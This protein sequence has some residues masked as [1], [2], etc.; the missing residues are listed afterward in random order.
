MSIEYET[1]TASTSSTSTDATASLSASLKDGFGAA[2]P[3]TSPPASTLKTSTA[4]IETH[5]RIAVL[6]SSEA[7]ADMQPGR[8]KAGTCVVLHI[9]VSGPVGEDPSPAGFAAR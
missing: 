7:D 5:Q 1:S 8:R 9:Q 2:M 6:R 4:P 3:A